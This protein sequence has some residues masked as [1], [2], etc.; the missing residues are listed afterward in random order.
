[1]RVEVQY[2]AQIKRALGGPGETVEMPT[3]ATVGDVLRTLA[4]R[5]ATTLLTDEAGAPE[6][7]AASFLSTIARPTP[8]KF[9]RTTPYLTI[10]GADGRGMIVMLR[11]LSDDDRARFRWQ[12]SVAGFGEARQARLRESAVLVSRIGG[13]GGTLALQLAAAGRRAARPRACRRP[14]AS[15][16][17]IARC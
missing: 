7:F 14:A 10:L 16:T 12:L 17:S 1:M 9:L 6:P 11:P 15:T 13:V 3:G 8:S 2:L 4:A 5:H